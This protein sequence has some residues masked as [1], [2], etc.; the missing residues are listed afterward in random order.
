[1]ASFPHH[2]EIQHWWVPFLSPN[3]TQFLFFK[4]LLV[5]QSHPSLTIDADCGYEIASP[6][7]RNAEATPIQTSTAILLW[8][9]HP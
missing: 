3:E 9:N 6:K 8:A 4:N 7:R 5:E 2:K 1:M